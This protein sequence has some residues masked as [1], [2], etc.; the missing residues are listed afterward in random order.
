RTNHGLYSSEHDPFLRYCRPF[1]NGEN[2]S[3]GI[4]VDA[5]KAGL[6]SGQRAT[7]TAPTLD[8]LGNSQPH[9]TKP[10]VVVVHGDTWNLGHEIYLT[11][12]VRVAAANTRFGQDENS[13]GRLPG[14]GATGRFV[15]EAAGG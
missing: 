1:G 9:R 10:M 13:H 2:F 3:R 15:R 4:D 11:G 5:A 6:I 14:G 7:S 8:L 12:D